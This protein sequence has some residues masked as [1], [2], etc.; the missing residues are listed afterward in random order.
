MLRTRGRI[1]WSRDGRQPDASWSECQNWPKVIDEAG[2][3]KR[4]E[5]RLPFKAVTHNT[6]H[7]TPLVS[8]WVLK[9]VVPF[10]NGH[11]GKP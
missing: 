3:G 10:N 9:T 7:V 5:S 1:R 4:C 2:S 11:E 8:H 6:V